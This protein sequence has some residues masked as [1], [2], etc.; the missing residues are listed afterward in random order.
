MRPADEARTHPPDFARRRRSGES[1]NV[2]EIVHGE[3]AF[4]Q[5]RSAGAE[6]DEHFA[7]GVLVDTV[8]IDR[9]FALVAE[10]FDERRPAFFLRRL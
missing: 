7:T 1:D 3:L 6:R 9:T 5:P 10:Q 4:A 2:E 8:Q